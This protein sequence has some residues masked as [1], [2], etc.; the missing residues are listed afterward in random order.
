MSRQHPKLPKQRE[1]CHLPTK[2]STKSFWHTEP[3]A[4]LL[5]HR[6]TRNIPETADVVIIGSGITGASIAHHLLTAESIGKPKVVLL[7]AR[8]ACWGATGRNGGHCQPIFFEHP[9]DPSIGRFELQTFYTLQN[10]IKEENIDCEFV[11]QP[12]VRAI[13]SRSHLN[14][15][16]LALLTMKDTAPDLSAMMKLV[17]DRDE[18][19]ALRIPTAL[20]AIVTDVA[21]RMWP[22]K[23][24]SHILENL[25]TSNNLSGSFNL[26]TLTPVTKL[27][28]STSHTTVHTERGRI[29]ASR[30][31][32]AT[33]A[34]TSHLLP[35]FSDLIVPCR[36]QMSSLIPA[37]SVSGESRLKTSLG[38]LGDGLDDYLIQRPNEK[39]GHLMFG[40]GRQ[41]GKSIG[42][43]DDSFIDDETGKYLRTRLVEA[44]NLPE[45]GMLE[46][47]HI[48]TGIMGFSRDEH[49]WVGKVPDME[50]VWIAA[51]FTGHG[52]PNTWL[53]GKA[54]AGMVLKNL[55]GTGEVESV[56]VARKET[57][58]PECYVVTRER[59]EAAL[60]L[61]DVESKDW[62]EME[63]GRRSSLS[64]RQRV[65]S[66][67]A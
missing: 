33:N 64:A 13:Y 49:P 43:T 46:A 30:V 37:P 48:W 47:T 22:Y 38:F 17:T 2:E 3:S 12:G 56:A 31:I 67:F 41:H 63:R 62:A 39:G 4:L 20:G 44:L 58:L 18:L 54:V 11:A 9:H 34:Y 5:G 65:A 50:N 26:Q 32:L 61:E 55:E 24:V 15:A 60:E 25:L 6:S 7:E 8:E 45:G 40:G 23:F 28:D 53:S 66:G 19:N 57:G 1:P 10:L 42:V 16:E 36:G 51:G 35:K 52:M 29:K 14:D 59:M 27:E 21:A